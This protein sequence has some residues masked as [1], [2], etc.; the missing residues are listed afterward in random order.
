MGIRVGAGRNV[1]EGEGDGLSRNLGILL[2]AK[3]R[4]ELFVSTWGRGIH[5]IAREGRGIMRWWLS[6]IVVRSWCRG[7][8]SRRWC[9]SVGGWVN[10]S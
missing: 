1:G 6:T 5:G 3:R 4:L 7:V 10:N 2:V 8:T 9:A